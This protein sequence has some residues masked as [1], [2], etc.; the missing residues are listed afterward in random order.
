MREI[1]ICAEHLSARLQKVIGAIR[2]AP[3]L[4]LQGGR[5]IGVI[6]SLEQFEDLRGSAWSRACRRPHFDTG[7]KPER[8]ASG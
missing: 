2:R 5:R 8:P 6:L 7:E 1:E 3:V 4:L